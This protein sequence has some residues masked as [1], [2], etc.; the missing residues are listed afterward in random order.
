MLI[1]DF[2]KTNSRAL[3]T[4]RSTG[5]IRQAAALMNAE[6]IGA[7]VVTTSSG[8]FEGLLAERDIVT[9]LAIGGRGVRDDA[10]SMWMR[11]DV[12]TVGP[13][14]RILDATTLITDERARHL[15]VVTDGKVIALLSVGDLLKCRL[16]E[17]TEENQV[18]KDIAR[19][20][21]ADVA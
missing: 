21:R 13:E 11:R 9:A 1:A 20:P 2:I 19:W 14:A 5:L 17:K 8:E 7:V 12:T 3:R 16:E 4:L 15:P 10:I 6:A 18:L